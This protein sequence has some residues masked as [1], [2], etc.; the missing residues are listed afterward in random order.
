MDNCCIVAYNVNQCVMHAV[1]EF[2]VSDIYY[3]ASYMQ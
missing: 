2:L 1:A 3:I